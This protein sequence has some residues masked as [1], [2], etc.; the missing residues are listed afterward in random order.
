ML[1]GI[2]ITPTYTPSRI[3]NPEGNPP[4]FYGEDFSGFS[5]EPFPGAI[6]TAVT[7]TIAITTATTPPIIITTA[8]TIIN[9]TFIKVKVFP[10]KET[11]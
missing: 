7:I 4:F 2:F 8:V 11:F 9:G 10:F 3:K 1:R 5:L 6:I